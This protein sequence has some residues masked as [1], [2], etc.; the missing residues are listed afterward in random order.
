[1]SEMAVAHAAVSGVI[2]KPVDPRLPAGLKLANRENPILTQKQQTNN[3][4]ARK[5]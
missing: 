1:M 4:R 3:R 2:K 5:C